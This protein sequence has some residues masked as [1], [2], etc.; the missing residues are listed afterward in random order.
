MLG[1]QH[2]STVANGSSLY[3]FSCEM[4]WVPEGMIQLPCTASAAFWCTEVMPAFARLSVSPSRVRL[5]ETRSWNSRAFV[6]GLFEP[7]QDGAMAVATILQ[8]RVIWSHRS[9]VVAL[10]AR[11]TAWSWQQS[12]QHFRWA[13][14]TRWSSGSGH[15]HWRR[16]LSVRYVY[17]Y[18][19][20]IAVFMFFKYI[21]Y[22]LMYLIYMNLKHI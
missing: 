7:Y 16:R 10:S 11:S 4:L 19:L 13:R 21:L 1:A 17:I 22:L 3:S 6:E 9:I 18:I 12:L 20:Y 5:P 8:T 14:P 15:V 2:C